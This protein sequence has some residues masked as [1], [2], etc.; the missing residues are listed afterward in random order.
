LWQTSGLEKDRLQAHIRKMK[1]DLKPSDLEVSARNYG[2]GKAKWMLTIGPSA[3]YDSGIVD[4]NRDDAF[5]AGAEAR[6][7]WISKG[8]LPK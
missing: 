5:R 6:L 7:G 2:P 1:K 8:R 4:G 3:P